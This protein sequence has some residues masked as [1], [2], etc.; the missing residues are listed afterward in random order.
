M[1]ATKECGY[2]VPKLD[3]TILEVILHT[4][5]NKSPPDR[6]TL[7]WEVCISDVKCMKSEAEYGRPPGGLYFPN[8]KGGIKAR[9]GPGSNLAGNGYGYL[10]L[11]LF[12]TVIDTLYDDPDKP[13]ISFFPTGQLEG[14]TC[15]ITGDGVR[16]DGALSDG[17][18]NDICCKAFGENHPL[19]RG[20]GSVGIRQPVGT[21]RDCCDFAK[22]KICQC[23]S[24]RIGKSR[25]PER[26]GS[27]WPTCCFGGTVD[28]P[29][30]GWKGHRPKDLPRMMI[31]DYSSGAIYLNENK[32]I[33]K[34]AL[35]RDI[36]RE[37]NT[38]LG[39][40]NVSGDMYPLPIS[41]ATGVEPHTSGKEEREPFDLN[42]RC[43]GIE[44]KKCSSLG[45][46]LT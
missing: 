8:F 12:G 43:T 44:D 35:R 2:C 24:A 27:L 13:S 20:D 16:P 28:M 4:D 41:Q 33:I 9:G 19:R 25:S 45:Y 10:D 18:G 46:W 5:T 39:L 1:A 3:L 29:F 38:I 7:V 42:C 34:K 30:Y 37:L 40:C 22:E 21:F 17:R 23:G 14:G 32:N 6:N 36:C 15:T 26:Q 31:G 11:R